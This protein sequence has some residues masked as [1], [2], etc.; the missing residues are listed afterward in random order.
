MALGNTK[1]SFNIV[2]EKTVKEQIDK[3]AKENEYRSSSNLINYLLKKYIE[4]R[5]GEKD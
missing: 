1:K 3:I 5:E 2:L 4:D